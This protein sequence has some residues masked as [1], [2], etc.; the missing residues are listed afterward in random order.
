MVNMKFTNFSS[1]N[2]ILFSDRNSVDD[3]CENVSYDYDDGFE[4]E[5]EDYFENFVE[6]HPQKSSNRHVDDEDEEDIFEDDEVDDP[7]SY[8]EIKAQLEREKSLKQLQGLDLGDKLR[9]CITSNEPVVESDLDETEFPKLN[10]GSSF[11]KE[12]ANY[13]AQFKP[14]TKIEVH[15]IRFP[16]TRSY[17]GFVRKQCFYLKINK[18]C[19]FGSHC[20]FSHDKIQRRNCRSGMDCLNPSCTFT[21]PEGFT[22]PPK[23]NGVWCDTSSPTPHDGS[24]VESSSGVGIFLFDPSVPPPPLPVIVAVQEEEWKPAV[25]QK[26]KKSPEIKK[27]EVDKKLFLCKNVY[28]VKEN[29]IVANDTCKF[30]NMCLFSHSWTEVRNL[31]TNNDHYLCSFK[32]KCNGV[33]HDFI[34]KPDSAG[35][36]RQVRKYKNTGIRKCYKLHT[37]EKIQDYII[38]TQT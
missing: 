23:K 31:I 34:S 27:P 10:T 26:T 13:I 8:A 19:P 20:K 18:E 28:V 21:H 37:N 1:L 4:E 24:W 9:W 2:N 32:E 5:E 30:K 25:K 7:I 16:V 33:T 36:I 38:R 14:T 11:L 15:Y 3:P 22:K 29:K 6:Q 17:I 35:V 12:K